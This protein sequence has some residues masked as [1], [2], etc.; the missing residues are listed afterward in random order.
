MFFI[1]YSCNNIKQDSFQNN[2]IWSVSIVD[3][4]M[5][6]NH[7]LI[8]TLK[9]NNNEWQFDIAF[10][11]QAIDKLGNIDE[12]YSLYNEFYI[13]HFVADDGTI[14]NQKNECLESIFPAKGLI[15]LYKR[16]G[17]EK[18]LKAINQ[19]IDKLNQYPKTSDKIYCYN[20]KNQNMFRLKGT[21]MYC[22]FLA[23]YAVEFNKPEILDDVSSQIKMIY[24]LTLDK[25]TDFIKDQDLIEKT[26]FFI[27][28]SM[29][30]YLMALT[31]V[32][33][34]IP[35]N[36]KDYHEL[37]EILIKS[38][39]AINKYRNNQ[40]GLFNFSGSQP[41]NKNENYFDALTNA[42][43][44]YVMAKG[45]KRCLLPENYMNI[46]NFSFNGYVKTFIFE[47]NNHKIGIKPNI[48]DILDESDKNNNKESPE[49]LASFILAAIELGR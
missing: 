27:S 7:L 13:D 28:R 43:A 19:L 30:W 2:Q 48:S 41:D 10:L 31:D 1:L 23:Q 21:Y 4:Y 45:S 40:N 12:K 29:M 9:I 20:I 6:E 32:L 37:N 35:E 18:Y 39:N 17:E 44:I 36:N 49:I 15:T 24:N 22:P 47:D 14:K 34:F 42:M 26:E 11:G 3:S 8:D 38:V 33:D 46:A 16:S 25:K 5:S